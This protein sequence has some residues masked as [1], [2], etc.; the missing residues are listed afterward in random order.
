MHQQRPVV[1]GVNKASTLPAADTAS[2]V[3]MYQN[4]LRVMTHPHLPGRR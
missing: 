3:D 1:L 2:L 4:L